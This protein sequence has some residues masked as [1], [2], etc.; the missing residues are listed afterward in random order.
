[1][2]AF[3]NGSTIVTNVDHRAARRERRA[4]SSPAAPRH[5]SGSPAA[6]A[7]LDYD[8]HAQL[9]PPTSSGATASRKSPSA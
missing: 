8:D 6:R 7:A 4:C 5:R 9:P 3:V 1:M 2:Q